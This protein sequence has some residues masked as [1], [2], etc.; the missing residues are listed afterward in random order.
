MSTL[1]NDNKQRQKKTPVKP[2]KVTP[3]QTKPVT[4]GKVEFAAPNAPQPVPGQIP[5]GGNPSEVSRVSQN[6]PVI[7]EPPS[8]IGEI[9]LGA[10]ARSGVGYEAEFV[11][12]P[13][14]P[15]V[16]TP[17]EDQRLNQ[18][19]FRG[20]LVETAFPKVYAPSLA[21]NVSTDDGY[22]L[23]G[24]AAAYQE[25][26]AKRAADEARQRVQA[27]TST[28]GAAPNIPDS[29]QSW[30][31]STA[32]W[33]STGL[34]RWLF[35]TED[36][37]KRAAAGEFNPQE[38]LMGRRGAGLGGQIMWLLN[39]PPALVAG[40]SVEANKLF[41]GT[42]QRFGIVPE[43]ADSIARNGLASLLPKDSP[44]RPDNI[45]GLD[46]QRARR[47]NNLL[48]PFVGEQIEDLGE[49][50][51]S[52]KGNVFFSPRRAPNSQWYTDIPGQALNLAFQIFNPVDRGID[53][54]VEYFL[55]R[56]GKPAVSV[57]KTPGTAP[58]RQSLTPNSVTSPVRQTAV[59]KQFNG[60]GVNNRPLGRGIYETADD[61]SP[62]S[63]GFSPL[64]R[65]STE[66]ALNQTRELSPIRNPLATST[67]QAIETA[68]QI[69]AK[70]QTLFQ[71]RNT[72]NTT[73]T[74][75]AL[76]QAQA[77]EATVKPEVNQRLVPPIERKVYNF[78]PSKMPVV[79]ANEVLEDVAKF[80]EALISEEAVKVLDEIQPE[81]VKLTELD[82]QSLTKLYDEIGE[83]KVKI[84]T[85]LDEYDQVF[86]DTPDI[87]RQYLPDIDDAAEP[88]IRTN[89]AGKRKPTKLTRNTKPYAVN[90]ETSRFYHGTALDIVPKLSD[91]IAS[92]RGELGQGFYLTNNRELAEM[93]AK[94]RLSDT[95]DG[96]TQGV[97]IKPQVLSFKGQV[98]DLLDANKKLPLKLVQKL[99]EDALVDWHKVIDDGITFKEIVKAVERQVTE[100]VS[101]YK[102]NPEPYFA[103]VY[104]NI[105]L[106]LRKLGFNGVFDETSG[107]ATVFDSQKL[108]LN[109]AE[110]VVKPSALEAAAARTNVDNFSSKAFPDLPTST[111]NL[112][113]SQY[114]LLEQVKANVDD[115]QA[116]VI[117][118][119]TARES[120]KVIDA[121]NQ[122]DSVIA[123]TDD[124]IR[125]NSPFGE[126]Q[127][128]ST[129]TFEPEKDVIA[130]FK[131][132]DLAESKVVDVV[133]PSGN[134]VI[135]DR[136]NA[137]IKFTLD[138]NSPPLLMPEV[139]K[140]GNRISVLDGKHRLAA[141][142]S[143]G[144]EEL[145]II[146]KNG[147]SQDLPKWLNK[148]GSD[149][150]PNDVKK[151]GDDIET[152]SVNPCEF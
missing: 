96:L 3:A 143:L 124:L 74:Q 44:L 45:L 109:A 105:G 33:A 28:R 132:S 20:Q 76:R 46:W 66:Q 84:E 39:L 93:Y 101:R 65:T 139:V 72:P 10:A 146:V 88:F 47:Q 92:L 122:A 87:S 73:S 56:G 5:I 110:D 126:M 116:S 79:A 16:W 2:I 147:N 113:D 82:T 150:N 42:L 6:P 115:L 34:N 69:Q 128:K 21:E 36:Q 78:H 23:I 119:I 98:N 97:T 94:A 117:A 121:I 35:G 114:R 133:T 138:P 75:A 99:V 120:D 125:V 148:V 151:L 70:P 68:S 152:R 1:I 9:D 63:L 80:D 38:G 130:M 15:S 37:Q 48:A 118:E 111:A 108:A 8:N 140:S 134:N 112:I 104:D 43:Q 29:S 52:E 123:S 41:S 149:A 71:G 19:P 102:V 12:I 90:I 49:A 27:L 85:Q 22:R 86:D 32:M 14:T 17:T 131:M 144:V 30:A 7:S 89:V 129:D 106:K 141:W 103:N 145:P 77:S 107:F 100:E 127:F 95:A 54:T 50:R 60:F 136:M 11:D 137:A 24:K 57:A 91:N 67:E 81:Q 4:S 18:D 26:E 135:L 83:S 64:V 58:T 40:A 51:G 53:N 25:Q 59:G 55:R 142:K 62:A 31:E 13:D 61:I